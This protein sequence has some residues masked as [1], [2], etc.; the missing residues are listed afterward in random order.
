M[1]KLLVLIVLAYTSFVIAAEEKIEP[2]ISMKVVGDPTNRVNIPIAEYQVKYAEG[3]FDSYGFPPK[4][5][6]LLELDVNALLNGTTILNFYRVGDPKPKE[7]S[8]TYV[9]LPNVL[10]P[11][12]FDQNDKGEVHSYRFTAT[13]GFKPQNY[14]LT[15]EYTHELR[16][17]RILLMRGDFITGLVCLSR[18]EPKA[19]K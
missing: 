9:P 16:V 4:P 17:L 1:F 14:S 2:V 3:F 7:T 15:I 11:D 19:E 5:G 6:D 18:Y 8:A 12:V 10:R 13:R